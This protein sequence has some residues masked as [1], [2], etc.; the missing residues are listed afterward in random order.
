MS[1]IENENILD[2]L[3]RGKICSSKREAR[4]MVSAGAISINGSKE[5]NLDKI[6]TGN[7]LIEEKVL[8][9]K[10]GKK[11]YFLGTK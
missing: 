11:N 10:K 5:T 9:L 1:L 7:D 3:I 2:M 8:L 4:E 6:I